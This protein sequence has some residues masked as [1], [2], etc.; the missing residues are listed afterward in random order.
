MQEVALAFVMGSHHRLG[1]QSLINS[2]DVPVVTYIAE[3][4]LSE[5][6]EAYKL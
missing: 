1:S 6:E 5:V 3:I 4:F 2:L